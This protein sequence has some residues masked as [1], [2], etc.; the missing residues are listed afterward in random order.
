MQYHRARLYVLALYRLKDVAHAICNC[1]TLGYLKIGGERHKSVYYKAHRAHGVVEHKPLLSIISCSLLWEA[2]WLFARQNVYV[3]SS[4]VAQVMG[5][6][7]TQVYCG[8]Y[9]W[10]WCPTSFLVHSI[11]LWIIAICTVLPENEWKG[12][13]F[14]HRGFSSGQVR[15]STQW[16]TRGATAHMNLL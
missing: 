5:E 16:H 8:H 2:F 14:A 15:V 10:Y 13:P 12:A 1:L 4:Q 3:L 7:P 6:Q 9:C 11:S